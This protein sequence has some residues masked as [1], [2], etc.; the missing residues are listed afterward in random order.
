[1]ARR[2]LSSSTS[3][4]SKSK[5]NAAA[6]AGASVV[7]ASDCVQMGQRTQRP[8]RISGSVGNLPVRGNLKPSPA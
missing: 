3:G 6:G 8:R 2:R 5:L 4:C 1:M 7:I